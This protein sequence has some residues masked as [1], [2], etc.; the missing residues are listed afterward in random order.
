MPRTTDN[1][2]RH[3]RAA[4]GVV[5]VE[6]DDE[7]RETYA[8][9]LKAKGFSVAQ[10]ANGL[11][12]LLQIKR[13][14]PT[15]VVL[16]LFMPRLGGLEALKWIRAFDPAIRV[17]VVTGTEEPALPQQALALGASAILKKPVALEM[18]L[19]A[20]TEA[21]SGSATCDSP[22]TESVDRS[23]AVVGVGRVL[24]VDDE[25]EVRALLED[26]LAPQGY[27]VHSVADGAEALRHI[28]KEAPDVMLLDI[29]MPRLGG[30]EALTAIRGLAPD[31]K[32]IMISGKASLATAKLTLAYGAFDYIKKPFDLDH[33][34]EVVAAGLL[35]NRV[36]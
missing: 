10:A 4:R 6:D 2:E 14:R 9:Y 15:T 21:S 16:D 24:V 33:L 32:V 11:E 17:V 20:L 31:V 18:L 3:E 23:S 30:V 28:I 5:L 27:R 19:S 22:T 7:L 13:V 25:A 1:A 26:V 36:D 35:W 12:A 8:D 34:R 29:D